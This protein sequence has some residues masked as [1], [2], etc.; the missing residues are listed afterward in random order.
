MP[1]GALAPMVFAEKPPQIPH[2]AIAGK[3]PR[4]PLVPRN[5]SNRGKNGKKTEKNSNSQDVFVVS[6]SISQL[7]RS[8]SSPFF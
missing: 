8:F 1:R 3:Q 4:A 2:R 5:A 6:S 7:S